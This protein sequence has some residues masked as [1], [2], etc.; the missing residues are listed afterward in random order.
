[1]LRSRILVSSFALLG[2]SL[3]PALT[4]NPASAEGFLDLYLG[5]GFP[6]DGDVDT[7]VVGISFPNSLDA[8]YET[9]SSSGLRGGYWFEDAAAFV[10]IGLDLSYYRASGEVDVASG[11]GLTTPF[12][13]DADFYAFP[14]TPLLMLR[15]PIQPTEEFPG[16]RVQPYGAI[17]PGLTLSVADVDTSRLAFGLDDFVDAS[18]DVGIDVRGGLAVHVAK[19]IALFAEYRYTRLRP[20]YDNEID[21]D[22][23]PDIDIDIEPDIDVHHMVFGVSFRF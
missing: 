15:V 23:G 11:L 6:E 13:I 7:K 21:D 1:M 14:I 4:A 10:G 9:T 17:G 3:A 22:F 12:E 20:D 19:P 18:F 16:G 8:D 2:L 5:A